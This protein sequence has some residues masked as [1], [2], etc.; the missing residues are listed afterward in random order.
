M[1]LSVSTA[2]WSDVDAYVASDDISEESIA[3]TKS[4]DY[5]VDGMQLNDFQSL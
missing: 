5:S 3:G 1:Y 2:S 4:D